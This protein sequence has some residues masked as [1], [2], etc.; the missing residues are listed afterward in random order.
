MN[1]DGIPNSVR[2]PDS[3]GSIPTTLSASGRG[4]SS[5]PSSIYSAQVQ[6]NSVLPEATAKVFVKPFKDGWETTLDQYQLVY[7]NNPSFSNGKVAVFNLPTLNYFLEKSAIESDGFNSLVSG[8]RRLS[9]RDMRLENDHF[10][11]TT[12]EGFA[13]RYSLL[14]AVDGQE[15]NS[16]SRG[17]RTSDRLLSYFPSGMIST[18]FNIFDPQIRQGDQCYLIT[19]KV[20][21]KYPYF[22]APNGSIVSSRTDAEMLQV[23]GASDQGEAVPYHST[24]SEMDELTE[25]RWNIDFR[26]KEKVVSQ[27]YKIVDIDENGI[28]RE[29]EVDAGDTEALPDLIYDAYQYGRVTRVGVVRFPPKKQSNAASIQQS[30]RNADQ[31]TQLPLLHLWTRFGY[32]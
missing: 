18:T 8:K 25:D 10:K 31:M 3:R 27:V 16:I 6:D 22:Y 23:Y 32:D 5:I 19:K 9:S 17:N 30:L 12:I 15:V 11:T 4:T 13:E 29:R 14:G 26:E 28:P 20:Q 21:S 7:A 24:H 1:V 2:Q